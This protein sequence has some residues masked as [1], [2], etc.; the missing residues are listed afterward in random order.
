MNKHGG[1]ASFNSFFIVYRCGE[2]GGGGESEDFA[3]C[4]SKIY[5]TPLL[6]GFAV[7]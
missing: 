4:H 2:G 1:S 3:L 6:L 5:Q 7:I